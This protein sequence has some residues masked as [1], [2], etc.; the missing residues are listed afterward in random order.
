[1]YYIN[2]SYAVYAAWA[3]RNRD[4][5]TES[6]KINPSLFPNKDVTVHELKNTA[7]NER[8]LE[9]KALNWI[10]SLLYMLI[11]VSWSRFHIAVHSTID[12]QEMLQH[13]HPI[14]LLTRFT[15]LKH[16]KL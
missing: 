4:E 9:I 11:L 1:M 12:A 7:T 10:L 8:M 3:L 15:C 14:E 2:A 16:T 13:G 6:C 5:L